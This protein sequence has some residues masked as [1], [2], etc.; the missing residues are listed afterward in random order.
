MTTNEVTLD[1]E[2]VEEF[3][4]RLLSFF[5][6]SMLSYMIDIGHRTG[7]F[8]AAARG[9]ATSDE[10]AERAGLNERYVREWLGAM[11]TGGIVDYDPPAKSY[12]LPPERA[13]CL[14]D[15]PSNMA[16]FAKGAA[17]PTPSTARSSPT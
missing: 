11:V 14:T 16:P 6:G 3:A 8:A 13:A 12:S 2:Q 7:L 15:G 17:C 1:R 9:P 10:L 4:G 5:S